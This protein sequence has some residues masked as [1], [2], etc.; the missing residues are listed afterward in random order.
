MTARKLPKQKWGR[1]YWYT[2]CKPHHGKNKR[3]GLWCKADKGER[4]LL[5]GSPAAVE[6][7]PGLQRLRCEK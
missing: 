4:C 5:C 7:Y 6:F 2:L 1:G 3:Q